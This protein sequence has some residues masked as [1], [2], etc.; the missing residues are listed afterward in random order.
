MK[1]MFFPSPSLSILFKITCQ[2]ILMFKAIGLSTDSHPLIH[3]HTH[4]VDVKWTAKDIFPFAFAWLRHQSDPMELKTKKGVRK[5]IR[6][7]AIPNRTPS[8]KDG[9]EGESGFC[10]KKLGQLICA[11][12][13]LSTRNSS[14]CCSGAGWMSGCQFSPLRVER[15]NGRTDGELDPKIVLVLPQ[16]NVRIVCI[17]WH[18]ALD[19]QTKSRSGLTAQT[20]QSKSYNL[21]KG[22][23]G[24]RKSSGF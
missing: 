21:L 13:K 10:Q 23:N 5:P 12:M 2:N 7:A 8:K 19:E 16:L 22:K 11:L 20:N 17:S 18:V 9:K 1:S 3:T 4:W 24:E 15:T 6:I 14:N